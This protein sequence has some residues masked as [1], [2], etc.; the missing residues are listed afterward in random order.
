MKSMLPDKIEYCLRLGDG[1]GWRIVATDGT[2][3]WVE[4]LAKILKLKNDYGGR[5]PKLVFIRREIGKQMLGRPRPYLVPSILEEEN[6]PRKGW[7]SRRIR[8][9]QI[10]SHLR[11]PDLIC[12]IGHERGYELDIL[13][14]MLALYPIFEKAQYSGGVSFHAALVERSGTGVLLA[15]PGSTGKS[16]CCRRF[17]GSWQPLCDDEALVVKNDEGRYL[18]HP[19][20]TWSDYLLKRSGQARRVEE[21]VPLGAI[22]FL[23]QAEA[24]EVTP[25]GQG[26]SAV[27]ITQSAMEVYYPKWSSL[28]SERLR[29]VKKMLFEN[30][31]ELAK[32]VP[33]F[34]LRASLTGRFWEKIESVLP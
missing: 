20:P 31:C 27:L 22:F 29:G 1:Q 6:L 12:E 14:M 30:A 16:T 15:A 8:A 9:I 4:K 28:D 26:Q 21:C 32:A 33:A 24:D 2:Q 19:L 11:V 10:W 7:K 25:V 18:A 17:R 34:R 23:E 3:S 13:R 5:H